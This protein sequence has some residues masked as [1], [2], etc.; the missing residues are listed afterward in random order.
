MAGN[1][2]ENAFRWAHSNVEVRAH[3]DDGRWV[4]FVIEDD[5]L[6]LRPDQIPHVL[7]PGERIDESAPGFGS[8]LTRQLRLVFCAVLH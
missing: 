2:L 1:L 3:R 7:R 4:T 8:S 6:G 5:G